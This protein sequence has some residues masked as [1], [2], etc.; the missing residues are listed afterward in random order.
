[1]PCVT[2]TIHGQ[3]VKDVTFVDFTVDT[4]TNG[5][6]THSK[7]HN[8]NDVTVAFRLATTVD[9]KE[10]FHETQHLAPHAT[11]EFTIHVAF[12]VPANKVEKHKICV[13]QSN[14]RKA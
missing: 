12:N 2:K 6:Y 1:M 5:A 3:Q 14:T 10:Q 11:S 4:H 13:E 8:P 9:G 7:V